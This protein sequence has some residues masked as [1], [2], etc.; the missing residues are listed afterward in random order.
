MVDWDGSKLE[1]AASNVFLLFRCHLILLFRPDCL[2]Q[3]LLQK[4]IH[5]ID[6]PG[7]SILKDRRI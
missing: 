3:V 4:A 6:K 7:S 1:E 2:V 5:V